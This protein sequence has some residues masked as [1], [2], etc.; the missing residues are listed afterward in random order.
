MSKG[1]FA[2][3]KSATRPL[4][5]SIPFPVFRFG[6][7][8]VWIGYFQRILYLANKY[9]HSWSYYVLGN[10]LATYFAPCQFFVHFVAEPL[11]ERD[12]V[13]GERI[14]PWVNSARVPELFKSKLVKTM[15]VV[16]LHRDDYL[17]TPTESSNSSMVG[18]YHISSG[19]N[20][21]A[22]F[23]RVRICRHGVS[24]DLA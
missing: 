23:L 22:H 2:L 9:I 24:I 8:R 21:I 1:W 6:R 4:I 10:V 20:G 19:W 11:E 5:S 12:M 3:T 14:F 18:Q 7:F 17:Y 15:S 13:L 16:N